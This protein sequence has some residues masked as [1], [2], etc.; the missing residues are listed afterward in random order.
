MHTAHFVFLA[1][2]PFVV[3]LVLGQ[4]CSSHNC[5]NDNGVLISC[6]QYCPDPSE[7]CFCYCVGGREACRCSPCTKMTA[8]E[9]KTLE[10]IEDLGKN[11]EEKT[12]EMIEDPEVLPGG[13]GGC[14]ARCDDGSTCSMECPQGQSCSCDCGGGRCSC[15]WC[16]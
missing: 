14:S 11:I 2:L 9:E 12:M 7:R 16:S 6:D 1:L 8:E 4:T 13:A 5:Y 10:I 3:A 15:T